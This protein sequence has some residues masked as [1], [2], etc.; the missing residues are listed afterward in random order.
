MRKHVKKLLAAAT[1]M[2]ISASMLAGC[3][4][5]STETN[6][7]SADTAAEEISGG[8]TETKSDAASTEPVTLTFWRA[9]TDVETQTY[10]EEMI[11]R[12][13]EKNPGVTVELSNLPW[14]DEI[15]TK[16]NAAYASG[17]APDVLQYSAN[18]IPQRASVGQY[19]PL[20]DFVATWDGKDDLFKSVLDSGK[21]EGKIYGLGMRPDA[22]MFVWRKDMFEAAG[23]DPNTPP[24]TWEEVKEFA[25]KLTI[26]KNGT[27]VQ[28]GY[29]ISIAN[30]FQ[31]FQIYLT[32]NGGDFIDVD[33]MKLTYDSPEA[34]EALDFLNSLVQDGDVIP[35]DQFQSG[36]DA[37]VSGKAAMAYKNPSDVQGMIAADPTLAD[38]IGMSAPLSRK[39]QSTFA[40]MGYMFMSQDSKNKEM[41]LKFIDMAMGADE[42]KVRAEQINIPPVRESLKTAYIQEKPEMNQAIMD[43]IQVGKGAYPVVFS[44][45]LNNKVSN[46]IEQVYYGKKSSKDALTESVT[47][48]QKEIDA[49]K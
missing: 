32:Q 1:V 7:P 30:G 14:G 28:G 34:I 41:A 6:A 40:G 33:T 23:L 43:S 17:T 12:F 8:T 45:E 19:A 38:K 35:S 4:K 24:K 3:G 5:N 21:Y 20:D 10:W 26:K 37:F 27:T 9:G 25:D 39:K 2:M 42:M 18:S 44:N 13:E 48:F 31:D 16:L 11:K 15:E 47:E 29:S 46:A 36:T 22:R 49:M